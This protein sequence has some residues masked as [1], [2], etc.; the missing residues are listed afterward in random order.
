MGGK[1]FEIFQNLEGISVAS[2]FHVYENEVEVSLSRTTVDN[3]LSPVLE[4][5][6]HLTN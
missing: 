3:P 5:K 1:L 4:N 2:H 6:S